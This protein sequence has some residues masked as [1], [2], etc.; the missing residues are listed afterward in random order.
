MEIVIN[1]IIKLKRGVTPYGLAPHKPILLLAVIEAFE[2]GELI[3]NWIEPSGELL[4]HFRNIWEQLVHT[5]H[6]P[7]F[8]L[9]FFHLKNEK[10]KFWELITY[11]GK[12]LPVTNSNSIKSYRA[13]VDCVAAAKLSEEFYVLLMDPIQ[14]EHIRQTILSTYFPDAK[15]MKQFEFSSITHTIQNEI[16]YDPAQNYVRRVSKIIAAKPKEEKE[17][18]LALRSSI[19]RKAVKQIYKQQCAIT[20]LKIDFSSTISMVD[21]CHIIP[22]AETQDDTV[23]NGIALSPTIHRAFDR[24]MLAISDNYT[25]L[26]HKNVRDYSQ[27]QGLTHYR[28][29]SIILPHEEKFYPSLARLQEHRICF[30]F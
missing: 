12:Q 14:R 15:E 23:T 1:N 27:G 30:G 29:Q 6:T 11:P 8:A 16:L 25:I 20:G 5:G 2:K 26:V 22:F 18:E 4:I 3:N 19:F 17:E 9:P 10:G 21:A 24:G 7:N 13:L 28:N